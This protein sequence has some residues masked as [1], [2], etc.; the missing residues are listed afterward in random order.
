LSHQVENGLK[1]FS[2]LQNNN[3]V[4][5]VGRTGTGKTCAIKMLID[6][7]DKIKIPGFASVKVIKVL[8]QRPF[9]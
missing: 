2:A 1:V 5:L 3:S 9:F 6:A 4:I 8:L 7:L